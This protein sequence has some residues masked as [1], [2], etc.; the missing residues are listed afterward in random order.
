MP[1]LTLEYTANIPHEVDIQD[2]L[3]KLHQVIAKLAGTR[4]ENFKSRAICRDIYY[5]GTGSGQEAF[6]HLEI[7]LLAGRSPETKERIGQQCLD[8][9]EKAWGSSLVELELQITVELVDMEHASYFKWA[10]AQT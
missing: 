10:P 1:H 9:L 4:I 8:L 5:I 6:V 7:R 2:L 3:A